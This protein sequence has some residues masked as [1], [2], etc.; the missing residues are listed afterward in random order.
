MSDTKPTG[1]PTPEE[2]LVDIRTLAVALQSDDMAIM[3]RDLEMILA[4]VEMAVPP[5]LTYRMQGKQRGDENKIRN[6]P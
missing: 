2:A 1:E 3:Q 5:Q 4:I 6:V